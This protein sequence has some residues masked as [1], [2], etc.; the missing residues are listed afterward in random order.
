MHLESNEYTF[1]SLIAY[2]SDKYKSKLS[3]R[4]FTRTDISQY[5]KRG[6]IP[7]RYGGH[8]VEE[9]NIKGLRIITLL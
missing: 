4:P 6:M 3:G 2:L 7:Y 9:K 5:L 8:K 1:E